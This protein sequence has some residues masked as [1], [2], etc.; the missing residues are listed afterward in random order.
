MISRLANWIRR[1][2]GKETEQYVTPAP[3]QPKLAP[4]LKPSQAASLVGRS[5]FVKM[6]RLPVGYFWKQ[7]AEGPSYRIYRNPRP[8]ER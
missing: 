4:I 7:D 1:L 5:F 3:Y 8:W 2:L 6:W